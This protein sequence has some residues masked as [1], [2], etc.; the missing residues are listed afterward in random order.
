MTTCNTVALGKTLYPLL[1][2]GSIQEDRPNMTE[3]YLTENK[4]VDI[5]KAKV[6]E[7]GSALL[8]GSM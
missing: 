1:R 3:K 2:T 8:F 6:N 7:T 5:V 4:V